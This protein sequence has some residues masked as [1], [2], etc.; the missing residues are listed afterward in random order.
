MHAQ[1]SNQ[2]R[3]I[4]FHRTVHCLRQTNHPQVG[5]NVRNVNG[6]MLPQGAM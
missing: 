6:G 3:E 4:M 5:L 1:L 2:Q